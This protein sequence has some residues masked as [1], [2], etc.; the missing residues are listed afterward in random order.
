M[1][2]FHTLCVFAILALTLLHT[3]TSYAAH[4][5]AAAID[6]TLLA[7]TEVLPANS[8]FSD[9]RV[10]YIVPGNS[11]GRLKLTLQKR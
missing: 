1:Q 10:T 3:H 8:P 5:T 11:I 4:V 6:S 7:P 2:R 9:P